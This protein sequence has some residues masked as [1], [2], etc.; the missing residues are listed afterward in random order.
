MVNFFRASIA[1]LLL[2]AGS[3]GAADGGVLFER[4]VQPILTR[5][6][7][8]CHGEEPKLK[9][10]VDLRLR[11]FMDKE[12]DGGARVIV[13]G[14]PEKSE[15][16]ALVRSGEMPDK[17]TRLSAQEVAVIEHWIADGAKTARP[18]PAELP[19]GPLV[20]DEE[21]RR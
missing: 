20:T 16:L 21:R 1:V 13:A 7:W 19:T 5:H 9:G 17:G 12:L 14:A 8:H 18:E 3:A 2:A 6:C 11:R 10:G 4:E 15:L